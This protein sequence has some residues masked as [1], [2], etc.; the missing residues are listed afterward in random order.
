MLGWVIS[1]EPWTFWVLCCETL[2]LIFCF[3]IAPMT[4][5]LGGWEQQLIRV[6]IPLIYALEW[7]Q[8]HVAARMEIQ[9]SLWPLLTLPELGIEGCLV[10]ISSWPLWIL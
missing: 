3:S 7:D 6:H 8:I 5:G 10:T 2:Y 4:N 1:I 9:A